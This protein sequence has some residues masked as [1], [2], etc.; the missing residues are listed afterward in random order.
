VG[1]VDDLDSPYDQATN[2]GLPKPAHAAGTATPGMT[3]QA[4]IYRALFNVNAR[5]GDLLAGLF[6]W[7]NDYFPYNGE[8][9][10]VV[11]WGLYCNE[12]ARA[13]VTDA[14]S[15]WKRADADRVFNW[16]QAL[17][18]GFFAGSAT[19]G[20]AAGYY[21]RYYPSTG[22]YLGLQESSGDVFVHNGTQFQFYNAGTL[23]AFLDMG[24]RAGY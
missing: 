21:Y 14:Y 5:H 4:N 18:P 2:A 8:A 6:F 13:V 3:Q 24:G 12:P 15:A 9:C 16:A 23:R 20:T 10:G 7:G 17:Y 19:S 22:T 11:D 1:Y